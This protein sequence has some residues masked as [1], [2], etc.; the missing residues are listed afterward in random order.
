MAGRGNTTPKDPAQRRRRN[1]TAAPTAVAKPAAP[2]GEDLPPGIVWHDRTRIWWDNWR[3]SAQAVQFTATDWDF[4]LDTALLHTQFWNGDSSV[5]AELRL[6]L[7]K[8]GVTAEDRKRLN[9]KPAQPGEPE[10]G[11]PAG[12]SAAARYGHLRAVLEG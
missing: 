5:S 9:I 6:R 3:R 4:L 12:K 2:L 11:K 7:T 10:A 1:K 8:L